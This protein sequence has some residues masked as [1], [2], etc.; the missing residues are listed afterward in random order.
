MQDTSAAGRPRAGGKF[1]ADVIYGILA[2]GSCILSRFADVLR[3]DILKVNTVERMARK[4]AEDIESLEQ[5]CIVEVAGTMAEGGDIF[6]LEMGEPVAIR[7]LAENMIRL[8][9]LT[10]KSAE[11]PAGDIAIV[12]TGSRPG[13]KLTE[14]LFFDPANAL[15]TSQP[16]IRR[17]PPA[18]RRV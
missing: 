6:M 2:S 12:E 5:E 16:K 17:T 13:E 18:S 10:V 11:N 9:G 15:P 8:A 3:E 1:I 4:L 14:E 7:D